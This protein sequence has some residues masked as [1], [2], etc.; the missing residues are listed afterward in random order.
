MSP[1]PASHVRLECVDDH[2]ALGCRCHLD[3][4]AVCTLGQC[5]TRSCRSPRD[6][7]SC[8][9]R[10]GCVPIYLRGNKQQPLA[11]RLGPFVKQRI[12]TS[13]SEVHVVPL[14]QTSLH[15]SRKAA[16][17]YKQRGPS[18]RRGKPS[19]VPPPPIT[20]LQAPPEHPGFRAGIGRCAAPDSQSWVPYAR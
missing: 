20:V 8:R 7:H 3:C 11:G 1:Y 6:L 16:E 9:R 14:V 10:R 18:R 4:R 17:A 2:L 5:E 13:V 15:G 12:R 19:S